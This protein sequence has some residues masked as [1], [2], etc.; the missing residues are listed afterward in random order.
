MAKAWE[1]DAL[2]GSLVFVSCSVWFYDERFSENPRLF[3]FCIFFF[4]FC[5]LALRYL[6]LCLLVSLLDFDSFS[7]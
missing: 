4:L 2:A 6:L 3:H 5:S 1:Y 7:L